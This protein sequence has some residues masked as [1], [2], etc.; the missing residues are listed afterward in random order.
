MY[1]IGHK[2][3]LRKHKEQANFRDQKCNYKPIMGDHIAYR[4]EILRVLGSGAFGKVLEVI[5]HK[6]PAGSKKKTYALKIL[7]K[8]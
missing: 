7:K 6:Q 2:A 8:S 1:Y 5:D 3:Y 4:F